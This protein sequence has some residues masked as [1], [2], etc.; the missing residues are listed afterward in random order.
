MGF[1]ISGALGAG[2]A[3]GCGAGSGLAWCEGSATCVA[4]NLDSLSGGAE[5]LAFGVTVSVVL[6]AC[7]VA[8]AVGGCATS[9]LTTTGAGVYL[10]A[11]L[12]PTMGPGLTSLSPITAPACSLELMRK[13]SIANTRTVM[14]IQATGVYHAGIE[15]VRKDKASALI[16]S[17]RQNAATAANAVLCAPFR[18]TPPSNAN[19]VMTKAKSPAT[20]TSVQEP[21]ARLPKNAA[22]ATAAANVNGSTCLFSIHTS[23]AAKES[24]SYC[25]F[26]YVNRNNFLKERKWS[27]QR[28]HFRQFAASSRAALLSRTVRLKAF[29]EDEC[30]QDLIEY[31]LLLAFVSLCAVGLLTGVQGN[32]SALWSTLNSAL[33]SAA[34]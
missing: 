26:S 21:A 34:P 10:A 12:V 27:P 18:K 17:R 30:G 29:W 5:V 14:I 4:S 7:G 11:G 20:A 22:P 8:T 25:R 2:M 15:L 32:T 16:G 13:R 1:A 19:N 31:S 6:K 3:E 9:R 28:E 23:P 24:F 33:A